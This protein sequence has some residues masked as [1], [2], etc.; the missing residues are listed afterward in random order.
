MTYYHQSF[1]GPDFDPAPRTKCAA[2]HTEDTPALAAWIE[3]RVAKAYSDNL[4]GFIEVVAQE[5]ARFVNGLLDPVVVRC[6]RLEA[7][8][9]EQ[10]AE[11][12]ALQER[13]VP[14]YRDVWREGETYVKG[15]VVTEGGSLWIVISD[16]T[17]NRPGHGG[18]EDWRLCVKR[19]RDAPKPLPATHRPSPTG[20][21]TPRGA[22]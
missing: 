10:R 19:G 1:R 21:A 12:T 15:D 11:I 14:T 2:T 18:N 8:I 5:V 4:P 3:Q 13:G 17:T 20:T 7:M 6:D 22:T 9:A 16:T